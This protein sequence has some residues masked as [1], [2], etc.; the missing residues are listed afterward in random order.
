MWPSTGKC[1]LTLLWTVC[2]KCFERLYNLIDQSEFFNKPFKCLT[3]A[4]W[5]AN[6][7][8]YQQRMQ[9]RPDIN[10]KKH[11]TIQILTDFTGMFKCTENTRGRHFEK[12]AETEQFRKVLK[13][14]STANTYTWHLACH[15]SLAWT[16][17]GSLWLL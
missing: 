4:V 12:P 11:A 9:F 1:S 10:H 14:F 6:H 5:L 8:N 2:S 16:P 13:L 7:S 17:F 15:Y 3:K